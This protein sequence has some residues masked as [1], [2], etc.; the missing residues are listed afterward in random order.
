M[1]TIRAAAANAGHVL[2]EHQFLMPRAIVVHDRQ[3]REL[4]MHGCPQHAGSVIEISVRLD[5]HD[6]PATAL[7]SEG[8][9]DRCRCAITHAARALAAEVAVRFVVIP[10]LGVMSARESARR[11]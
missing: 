8:S 9:A 1:S 11:R 3:H 7:R 6:D 2:D 4:V 10:E 5:I